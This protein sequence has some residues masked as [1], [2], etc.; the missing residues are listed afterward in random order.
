MIRRDST[1]KRNI[2]NAIDPKLA[3]RSQPTCSQMLAALE[4]LGMET[5][6]SFASMGII[7]FQS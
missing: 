4:W 2:D 5:G 3:K 6:A 7:P 1:P